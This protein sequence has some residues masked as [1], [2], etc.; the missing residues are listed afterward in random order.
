MTEREREF[1]LAVTELT[2]EYASHRDISD[3]FLLAT[4]QRQVCSCPAA[5]A[6]AWMSGDSSWI[7]DI[8]DEFDL[9]DDF[10]ATYDIP[11]KE[12]LNIFLCSSED[13]CRRAGT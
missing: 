8:A 7:E 6:R 2:R 4:P 1:Y 9:D 5:T 13:Y 10:G 3:G 11:L 12:Y